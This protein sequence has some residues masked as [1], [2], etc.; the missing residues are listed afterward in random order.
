MERIIYHIEYAKNWE[1]AASWWEICMLENIKYFISKEEKNILLTTEK[2]KKAFINWWLKESEFLKYDVIKTDDPSSMVR[3]L[4]NYFKRVFLAKRQ[5]KKLKINDND[6]IIC[7][8][9]FFPNSLPLYFLS[10]NNKS[11]IFYY[12]HMKYPSI[13]K[14]YEWEFIWKYSFPKLWMI[15]LKLSQLLYF[16][17]MKKIN[18]WIILS[19]NS[20]YQKY[21]IEKFKFFNIKTYTIKKYSGINIPNMSTNNKKYDCLW[22]WRFHK[23][24]WIKE[25]ISIVKII[26]KRKNDIRVVVMWWWNKKIEKEFINDIHINWLEKNIIYKWFICWDEKYEY[27]AKSKIF[28]MTSYFES[29]GQV[30]LEAMKFWLPVVAYDLP[31]FSLFEKGM[32]K[33]K[34]LNNK[35]F[36]EEVYKLLND[37]NLYNNES[38]NALNFSNKFSWDK[39]W[40][41]IYNLINN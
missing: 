36:A 29:F 18:R 3:L 8:S 35:I 4:L 6:I 30:N 28:L 24:K 23:Q 32:K 37:I 14:W 16:F 20:F 15:Y 1:V 11:K 5:I 2:W 17:I 12:F 19:V 25:L 38:K 26:K 33:V 31:V 10:K 39:T 27:I 7:H 41:E 13:F 40:D 34:I 22:I 9:D 21:L